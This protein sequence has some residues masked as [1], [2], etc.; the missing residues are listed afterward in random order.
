MLFTAAACAV[1]V[2]AQDAFQPRGM[3]IEGVVDLRSVLQ[4]QAICPVGKL[5][6]AT[7]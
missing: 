7:D 3:K 5:L 2:S 6:R 1:S 4:G